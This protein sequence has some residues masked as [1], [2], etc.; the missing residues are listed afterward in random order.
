LIEKAA[1]L[2]DVLVVTSYAWA[3]DTPEM[4][5][6]M[7]GVADRVSE[8][9]DHLE[10]QAQSIRDAGLPCK[11]AIV[12]WNYWTRASHNDHAGF[13]EPN[14]IRH[15]LYA[16][17]YINAFCRQGDLMETANYYSLVNTM[18]MIQ[19][20]DGAVEITDVAKVMNLY[21]D[22]LP[23]EVLDVTHDAPALTGKSRE[24]DANA[25]RTR[26]ATYLFLTNY[27]AARTQTVAL[28][29]LGRIQDARGI[30][31]RT[32]LTPVTEFKPDCGAGK[33]KLPPMS[34]VRLTCAN[35][36]ERK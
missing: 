27:S 7:K 21:A 24:V 30:R 33:I 9:G 13:R 12:E 5:E 31:A 17:G 35:T 14:D 2:F 6:A 22:A 8:K 26:K 34:L 3:K 16:A 36:R 19:V 25:I 20:R 1:D 32:I 23:G 11:M 10:R 18:G 28:A 4:T 29:G 15:C